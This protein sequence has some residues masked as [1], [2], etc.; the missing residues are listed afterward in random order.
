MHAVRVVIR[1]DTLATRGSPLQGV[2]SEEAL[3]EAVKN[4]FPGKSPAMITRL[5]TSGRVQAPAPHGE[6][7]DYIAM[8]SPVS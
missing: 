8:L 2:I 4:A 6:G 1:R 7:V 3:C 5:T